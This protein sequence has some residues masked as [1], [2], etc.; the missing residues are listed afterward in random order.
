MPVMEEERTPLLA[1]FFRDS[2]ALCRPA[3]KEGAT[4]SSTK[5][6]KFWGVSLGKSGA[7]FAQ[8]GGG[9]FPPLHHAFL[10]Q[11]LE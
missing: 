11:V 8:P 9:C 6:A 4:D 7:H 10:L 3:M 2:L 5:Q 1:W